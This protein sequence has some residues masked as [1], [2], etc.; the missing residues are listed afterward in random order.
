MTAN[1]VDLHPCAPSHSG[2]PDR[3]APEPMRLQLQGT[4]PRVAAAPRQPSPARPKAGPADAGGLD[5]PKR[6][7]LRPAAAAG[8]AAYAGVRK[9]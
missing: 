4:C 7:C 2:A 6:E 5:A 8:L 1:H 9:V 3:P